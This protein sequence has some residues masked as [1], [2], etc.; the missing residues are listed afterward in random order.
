[1]NVRLLVLPSA[2]MLIYGLYTSYYDDELA[3]WWVVPNVIFL[4]IFYILYPQIEHF[5]YQRNPPTLEAGFVQLFERRFPF[6]TRLDE[7]GKRRFLERVVIYRQAREFMPMAMED[8]PLD[9]ETVVAASAVWLTFGKEDFLLNPYERFIIYRGPFPTPLHGEHWH[10]SELYA[11]D[12]VILFSI[13]HLMD[14][15][16]NPKGYFHVGLYELAK[17]YLLAFKFEDWPVWQQADWAT[18]EQISGMSHEYICKFIGLPQ[19]DQLAVSIVH[20]LV[21]PEKFRAAY[22]DAYQRYANNFQFDPL[23]GQVVEDAELV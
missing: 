3:F 8:V 17:A 5:F 23:T 19:V 22:P 18:F 1:M 9:V 7:A 14:S 21:W 2:L 11:E 12:E 16:L 13:P 20:Y 10:V 15:F 4:I 6:F